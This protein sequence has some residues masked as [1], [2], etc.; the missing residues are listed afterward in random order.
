MN[1]RVVLLALALP[2]AGCMSLTTSMPEVREIPPAE[3]E[4]ALT[5]SDAFDRVRS[6][7]MREGIGVA[8]ADRDG[9]LV[10]SDWIRG[11]TVQVGG[12]MPVSGYVEH[13][14]RATIVPE[15]SGSVV[16]LSV[17]GRS[18]MTGSRGTTTSSEFPLAECVDVG[19]SDAYNSCLKTVA[20]IEAVRDRVAGMVRGQEVRE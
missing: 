4:L 10:R 17:M 1:R 12:L 2:L 13:Y 11:E 18:H 15:E 7:F 14:I 6:A 3:I 9:G 20:R 5:A 16:F 19:R 8:E